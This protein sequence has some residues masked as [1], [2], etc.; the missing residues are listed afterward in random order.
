MVRLVRL[1]EETESAVAQEPIPVPEALDGRQPKMKV[2]QD[3]ADLL[4]VLDEVRPRAL[5]IVQAISDECSRQGYGSGTRDDHEPSFQV[6]IGEDQFMFTLSEEFDRREVIDNKKAFQRE[7]SWQRIPSSIQ[8]VRSGRLVRR[9]GSGYGSVSWADRTR[10]TLD[11]KLLRIFREIA[12][13][14]RPQAEKRRLND[15]QRR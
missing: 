6:G 13:R 5:R 14:A 11:Q 7:Y 4:D 2:F 12:D 8:P 10:W 9:L 3:N 15:E 1:A